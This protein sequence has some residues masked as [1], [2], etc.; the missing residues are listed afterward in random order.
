MTTFSPIR[1]VLISLFAMGAAQAGD[2]SVASSTV[3][4]GDLDLSRAAGEATL[5]RRIH[6]AARKVCASLDVAQSVPPPS[7][8]DA[9]KSCL[10]HA[11]SG[12]V[13]RINNPEFTAYV[14]GKASP[15]S[16]KLASR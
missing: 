2:L 10:A 4:Y 3:K 11:V 7:M 1:V 8:G 12:A 14:S 6:E 15:A 9:Y 5:Y 13:A 16:I